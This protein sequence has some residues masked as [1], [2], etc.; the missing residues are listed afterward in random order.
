MKE[1]YS[2]EAF[3]KIVS[4]AGMPN[5]LRFFKRLTYHE[6]LFVTASVLCV[7]LSLA[8]LIVAQDDIQNIEGFRVV[9]DYDEDMNPKSK[10]FGD[11][12]Q[13]LPDGHANIENLK[14]EFFDNGKI[15][16]HVRS[17]QCTYDR[18][19]GTGFSTSKL[20]ISTEKMVVTGEDY[21][22]DAKKKKIRIKKNVKVVLKDLQ[23]NTKKENENERE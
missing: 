4:Q 14:L 6:N 17:P 11:V 21:S 13:M 22:F 23:E 1:S 18:R 15:N 7:F 20:R 19:N 10:L 8:P 9:L 2:V 5:L 12:A 3:S 16:M